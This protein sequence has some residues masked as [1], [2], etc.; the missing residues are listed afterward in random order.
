MSR[1]TDLRLAREETSLRS[2]LVNRLRDLILDGDLTPGQKLV[3]RDLT[4]AFGVSRSLLRE[5]LQQLQAEGLIVNVLHRGPSVAV[6]TEHEARE[7]YAVRALLESRAGRDFVENATDDDVD[8]LAAA[9][10]AL[11]DPGVQD[12]PHRQLV[13]KNE[14]YAA[15]LA[16][17]G[18][19][20]IA[21]LLKQLNNRV[22]MLRRVSLSQ[23]GRLVQTTQELEEIVDAARRRDGDLIA[24]LL[25]D[26][27]DRAA[28]LALANYDLGDAAS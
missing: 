14:F 26:H 19:A 28:A 12:D 4:E 8:A 21:Q 27:V 18:N 5:A 2:L 1:P 24:K 3:E 11:R 7:I 9:V 10:D 6:I 15:L 16:G 13:V 23:P 20:T 25:S 17:G 22:T